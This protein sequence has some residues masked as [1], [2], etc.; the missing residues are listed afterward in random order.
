MASGRAET[1]LWGLTFEL[2]GQRRLAARPGLWKMCPHPRPR[3]GGMPLVLRLS[4]GLG[5]RGPRCACRNWGVAFEES[6]IELDL[7]LCLKRKPLFY[8]ASVTKNAGKSPP[9]FAQTSVGKRSRRLCGG[10][11]TDCPAQHG[12]AKRPQPT[13]SDV[14]RHNTCEM[15]SSNFVLPTPTSVPPSLERFDADA[16]MAHSRSRTG[17]PRRGRCVLRLSTRP[18]RSCRMGDFVF[19]PW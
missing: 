11:K 18:S 4:E 10:P 1:V 14:K 8:D 15:I 19:G 16:A 13:D 17:H 9:L 6:S 5:R 12:A 2:S 3:P 7:A